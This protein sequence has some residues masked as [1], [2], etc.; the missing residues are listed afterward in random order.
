MEGDGLRK[1]IFV[2]D[3]EVVRGAMA[4]KN[5]ARNHPRST[6]N[7]RASCLTFLLNARASARMRAKADRH[8]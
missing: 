5:R 2:L 8:P 3:R 1:L 6:G 7:S 4:A